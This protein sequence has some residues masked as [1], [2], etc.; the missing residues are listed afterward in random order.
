VENR[1]T[2]ATEVVVGQAVG[3]GGEG[4]FQMQDAPGVLRH[5]QW[6]RARTIPGPWLEHACIIDLL[7]IVEPS[8]SHITMANTVSLKHLVDL[9][10]L[11]MSR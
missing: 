6:Y 2:A 1:K 11:T 4:G 10:Q 9:Q 7:E 3:A 8:T 5:F